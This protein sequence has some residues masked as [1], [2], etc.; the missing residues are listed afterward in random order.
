MIL[1]IKKTKWKKDKGNNNNNGNNSSIERALHI[2]NIANLK[3]FTELQ[4]S[5]LFSIKAEIK[6]KLQ[7][8]DDSNASYSASLAI[9]GDNWKAWT[10]WGDFCDSIFSAKNDYRWAMYAMISYLCSLHGGDE[11]TRAYWP[12]NLMNPIH[13]NYPKNNINSH[14]KPPFGSHHHHGMHMHPSH[15]YGHPNNPHGHHNQ[16][17]IDD[18]LQKHGDPEKDLQHSNYHHLVIPRI[19]M[20]IQAAKLG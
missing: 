3:Y 5:E 1:H 12:D 8:L 15:H 19:L 6:Q 10:K 20:L 11:L 9:A 7:L 4:K 2:L 17:N 16:N 18:V 13:P 14:N